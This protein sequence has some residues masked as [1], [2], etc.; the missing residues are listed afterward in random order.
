MQPW[1]ARMLTDGF[2][3]EIDSVA[4]APWSPRPSLAGYDGPVPH[5]ALRGHAAADPGLDRHSLL[6]TLPA[7]ISD[8]AGARVG[9]RR[10]SARA[11]ER[12]WLL[13]AWTQPAQGSSHRRHGRLSSYGGENRRAAGRGS[14][15]GGGDRR[16][17]VRRAY[18]DP[19]RQREACAGALFFA[20]RQRTDVETGG[21][22]AAEARRRALYAGADGSRRHDLHARESAL[23]CLP[24]EG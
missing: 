8:G 13:R 5:L 24:G 4:A 9:E 12:A 16:V 17:C 21:N 14:L 11:V 19:R 2:C 23:R 6:P 18:R 7:E 1:S 22:S 3:A 10:R 20:S 15:H